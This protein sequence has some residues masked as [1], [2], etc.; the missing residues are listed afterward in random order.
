MKKRR[1]FKQIPA[2]YDKQ[3]YV[4][5]SFVHISLSGFKWAKKEGKLDT[6]IRPCESWKL[7][8]EYLSVRRPGVC[9]VHSRSEIPSFWMKYQYLDFSCSWIL[10]CA[11]DQGFPRVSEFPR[12]FPVKT[13]KNSFS[14]HLGDDA[15]INPQWKYMYYSLNNVKDQ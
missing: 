3:V 11:A 8:G 4:I 9:L 12:H 7:E 10:F 15:N 5:H 2:N 13:F 6:L 14:S 1:S